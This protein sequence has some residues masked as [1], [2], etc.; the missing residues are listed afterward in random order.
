[1]LVVMAVI[2]TVVLV[3]AIVVVVRILVVTVAGLRPERTR[4]IFGLLM[5]T[6]IAVA[7]KIVGI[8]LIVALL[9]IPAAT[10][11]RCAVNP[12][13]MAALAG[14]AGVLSI[15]AGLLLFAVTRFRRSSQRTR[16]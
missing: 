4:L 9:V 5:A 8:L 15:A 12:E 11:R 14:A 3:V 7:I 2:M 6:V 16:S 13:Q 1:M 10:A